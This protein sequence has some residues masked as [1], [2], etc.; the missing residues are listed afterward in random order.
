ML[1]VSKTDGGGTNLHNEVDILLVMLGE[2]CVTDAE[3]VLVTGYTAKGVFLTVEDEAVVGVNAEGAAAEAAANVIKYGIAILDLYLA[4]IEVGVTA[5]VPEMNVTNIEGYL[6]ITGLD[7]CDL[8]LFLVVNGIN[9]SLGVGEGGGIDLDLDLCILAVNGGGDL[10]TGAAVVVKI[11]VGLAGGD[12]V[13]VTVKTAVEGEVC[14]LGVDGFVGSVVY[15]D[16]DLGI[17]GD[18]IGEVNAPGG[19]T[20]IVVSELLAANV[21]VS[22]GVS[23]TD[24]EVVYLSLGEGGLIKSLYVEAGA[25]EV[26]VAAVLTVGCIPGVGEVN[27]LSLSYRYVSGILGEE[28]IFVKVNNISQVFFS[29]F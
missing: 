16:S 17:I 20:A 7:L 3:A 24:L 28:P 5:T 26:I 23:A 11:E 19:V 18:L 10:K 2:K 21:N 14:H 8:V 6:G 12:E 4:A 25:T 1:V 29:C 22:R 13:Y 27:Y 15:Y 9:E